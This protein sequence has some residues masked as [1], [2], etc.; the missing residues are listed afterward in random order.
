MPGMRAIRIG[1]ARLELTPLPAA[2]AAALPDDRAAAAATIG[3]SLP[4]AWP[5]ADL[6]EVLAMHAAAEPADERFGIWLII[7]RD[8]NTVVGDIGFMGPPDGGLVEMGFSVIPDRRRRGYATEAARS[9]VDWAF[10]DPAIR[11]IT[12]RSNPENEPSARVLVA[13]GFA[14]VDESRGVVRWRRTRS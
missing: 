9:L 1:G 2:A 11:E 7:E 10:G 13:A 8:T 6:L 5:Q 14:R 3:S 4:A 12:A